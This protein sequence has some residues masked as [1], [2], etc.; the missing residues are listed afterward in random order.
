MVFGIID[1][2]IMTKA[3]AKA[4]ANAQLLKWKVKRPAIKL[5]LN[6]VNNSLIIGLPCLDEHESSK[7]IK[8]ML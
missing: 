6:G 1:E 7:A 4:V 2:N 3:D 8:W 5:S